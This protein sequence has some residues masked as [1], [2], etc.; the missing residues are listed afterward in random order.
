MNKLRWALSVTSKFE[1]QDQ[2]FSL[3]E[4]YHNI[5]VTFNKR[6]DFSDDYELD[7][8]DAKWIASTLC[9]WQLYVH[10]SYFCTVNMLLGKYLGYREAALA[11][12]T[13]MMK[14]KKVTL[15]CLKQLRR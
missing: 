11:R 3:A 15:R 10:Y 13:M 5:L 14:T 7:T 1:D 9:W 12:T 8:T 2:D 6:L 4:F